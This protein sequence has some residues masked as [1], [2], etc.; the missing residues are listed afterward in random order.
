MGPSIGITTRLEAE[1]VTAIGSVTITKRTWIE[2]IDSVGIAKEHALQIELVP[3]AN[4]GRACFS[5]H[6]KPTQFEPI[7]SAFFVPASETIHFKSDCRQYFS[8]SC[9]FPPKAIQRWFDDELEWTDSRLKG[10]LNIANPTIHHLLFR[11]G[12]ELRAPSFA[13]DTLME[14][15]SAEIAVELARYYLGIEERRIPGGLVPWRMR[16]ID[17]RLAEIGNRPSLTELAALCNMSARQLT[18]EFRVSHGCS[19]GDYIAQNRIH[20]AK[21]LLDADQNVKSIAHELGFKSPSHFYLAFHRATGETP[22]Q[23]RQR[24]TRRTG[25]IVSQPRGAD[26]AMGKTRHRRKD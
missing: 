18:R 22:R 24:L 10:S 2:P 13:S 12:E 5:D 26:L 6:W 8:L 9:F 25:I 19:I 23:Y 15:I 7:G 4:K 1:A 11:L 20:Q 14:L 3:C 21:R 17:E 16:L